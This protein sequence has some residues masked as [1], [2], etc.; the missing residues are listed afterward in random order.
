[1]RTW[2][3]SDVGPDAALRVRVEPG[4]SGHPDLETDAIDTTLRL[5]D[6]QEGRLVR[7]YE[8]V[9]PATGEAGVDAIAIQIF[10]LT[11][12]LDQEFEYQDLGR[13]ADGDYY[14]VRVTQI[15]GERAWSSPWWVGGE[16]PSLR[17]RPSG[18]RVGP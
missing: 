6:A 12:S 11:D 1:M 18:R 4:V 17:T 7:E 8:V 9:D 16:P 13:A 10:S 14:Y 15:D 5:A 3:S 2:S